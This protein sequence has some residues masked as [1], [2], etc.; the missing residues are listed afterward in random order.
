MELALLAT[1]A[2]WAHVGPGLVDV[3][4]TF[5]LGTARALVTP[6]G[7]QILINGPDRILLFV[8]DHHAVKL[9]IF[10]VEHR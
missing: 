6:P 10:G 8:V 9:A 1:E 7:R 2:E 5:L 4:K 3:V